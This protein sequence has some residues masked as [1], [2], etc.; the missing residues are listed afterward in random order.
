MGKLTIDKKDLKDYLHFYLGCEVLYKGKV[1]DLFQIDSTFAHIWKKNRSATVCEPTIHNVKP[2]LR[3][4]SSMTQ[5]EADYFAWLCMDSEYHLEVDS[6]ITQEEIQT[7]LAKNDDGLMLDADVEI[8]IGV[9]VR[10]FEGAVVIKTDGSI[11]VYDEDKETYQSVDN[12]A[13]K[14]LYLLKQGFDLFGLIPAGLAIDSTT[15]NPQHNG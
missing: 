11:A 13:F 3:P 8:Y 12:I 9:S 10:C 14:V 2:L 6:R 5:S 1:Y 15:L 7:E 4:L